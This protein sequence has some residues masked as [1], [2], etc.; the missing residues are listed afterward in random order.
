[1]KKWIVE[2]KRAVGVLSVILALSTIIRLWFIF[3]IPTL[4]L[5]DFDTYYQLAVNVATGQGYT[6]GGY[7]IAWQGMLY[8]TA[9]GMVFK[10]VGSTSLAIPKLLNV[11][12]SEV[13]I[14]FVFA[15]M[16]RL[17]DKPIAVWSAVGLMAFMPQ[18]IAYCNV[19]GTEI[20]TAFLLSATLLLSTIDLKAKVKYP[21]LGV[22]TAM[23]ALSK[24]FYMAYPVVLG[25]YK[26]LTEKNLKSALLQFGVV[27]LVM[28]LVIMPWT[29]RNYQKY[30]RFIP[31]SY[32]SGFNL[33]I[34]NNA[35]NVHGGW[36]D[37][38]EINMPEEL[39]AEIESQVAMNGGTVKTAY[40]LEVLMKPYAQKWIASNPIEFFKLGVIRT[41]YTYFSGAWDISAWAM[42]ELKFDETNSWIGPYTFQ[43][44]LNLF[45]A[46][47]DITLAFVST[48]GCLFIFVNVWR[49]LKNLFNKKVLLASWM[50]LPVINLAFISLVY[51]VY[52]GQPRY[53]FITLFMLIICFGIGLE[54]IV[55]A[56][57]NNAESGVTKAKE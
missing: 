55:S 29:I 5:Y 33:F 38:H 14:I 47:S 25:V 35:Q 44:N 21:L 43:R 7:P 42:N 17:Y 27:F 20:E 4:Q 31:I 34:N 54:M 48:F 18:Q 10:I 3:N 16:K 19:V 39:E 22:L 45:R 37:Y 11:L 26:W 23:L 8:S 6:L 15:L 9:L 51:F 41:H 12:M 56:M 40:N 13:T 28:W 30:D 24:P 50:L 32:N 57:R 1:M 53:N 49:I 36:M 52:E 46:I 2:N